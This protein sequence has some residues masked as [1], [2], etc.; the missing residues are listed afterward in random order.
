MARMK[1]FDLRIG[2]VAGQAMIAASWWQM[3]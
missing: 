1:R 2:I 3:K